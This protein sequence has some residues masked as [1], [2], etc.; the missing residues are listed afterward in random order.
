MSFGKAGRLILAAAAIGG[1]ILYGEQPTNA[2]QTGQQK[3]I[4]ERHSPTPE[5][6][7]ELGRLGT[8]EAYRRTGGAMVD[9]KC[10]WTFDDLLLARSKVGD[11]LTLKLANGENIKLWCA[12]RAN[13]NQT[14]SKD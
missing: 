8:L 4:A 6:L 10:E 9:G 11:T 13:I 1:A 2:E 14:A 5:Q 12:P 7:K 3:R